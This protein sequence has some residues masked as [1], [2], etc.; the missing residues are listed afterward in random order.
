MWPN[1]SSHAPDSRSAPELRD[2]A[3]DDVLVEERKAR[4]P[5]SYLWIEIRLGSTPIRG[6]E[7]IDAVVRDSDAVHSAITQVAREI[8]D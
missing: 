7:P 1:C 5:R 3:C 6:E 4:D 2:A 8:S